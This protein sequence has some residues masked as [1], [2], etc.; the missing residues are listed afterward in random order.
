[1]KVIRHWT[2]ANKGQCYLR[3]GIREADPTTTQ[4]THR[5]G[6]KLLHAAWGR[7]GW[8]LRQS[9][10]DSLSRESAL[11]ICEVLPP[12]SDSW[13][14]RAD[15]ETT[16]AWENTPKGFENVPRANQG[17]EQCLLTPASHETHTM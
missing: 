7:G 12:A 4:L 2:S 10:T 17:W 15:M 13:S 5:K 6:C 3:G 8:T 14:E 1:M 16:Q 11:E 9:P